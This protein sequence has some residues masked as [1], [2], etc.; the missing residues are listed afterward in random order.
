MHKGI[1]VLLIALSVA[2]CT[3]VEKEAR[4]K[5]TAA[6]MLVERGS[7]NEALE[8][9]NAIVAQHPETIAATDALKLAAPLKSDQFAAILACVSFKE[10]TGQDL[11]NAVDLMEKSRMVDGWKGPYLTPSQFARFGQWIAKKGCKD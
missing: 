1:F 10:D 5:L 3:D 6:Q 9:F 11:K 2:G 4:K 8:A 7:Y